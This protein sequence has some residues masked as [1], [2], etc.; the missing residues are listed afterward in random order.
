MFITTGAF[1]KY[2]PVE[3]KAYLWDEFSIERSTSGEVRHIL[4]GPSDGFEYL[5]ISTNSLEPGVASK[6]SQIQ[7]DLETL[8]IIKAGTL[9]QRV[10]GE[11]KTLKPGSVSLILPGDAH[12]I[13]NVGEISATYYVLRWRTK[14]EYRPEI[15]QATSTMVNWDDAEYKPSA[16]GGR[17]NIMRQPTAMMKEF[18]MHVTTLDEGMKSHDPHT[19]VAE[20]IILVRYGQVEEYID[21]KLYPAGPGSVIFLGSNVPHG[22]RNIGDGPCEYYAFQ[23]RLR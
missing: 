12:T 10:H 23:W 19:H 3:S 15:P 5:S 1:A 22:I 4:E 11:T 13:R 16:K 9:E 7:K 20:E 14:P 17:R 8:I 6:E 18:E 2:G 21:G